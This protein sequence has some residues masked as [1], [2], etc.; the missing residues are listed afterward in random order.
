MPFWWIKNIFMMIPSRRPVLTRA[1]R[2]G[3]FLLAGAALSAAQQAPYAGSGDRISTIPDASQGNVEDSGKFVP[4]TTP[5]KI[6]KTPTAPQEWKDS[7]SRLIEKTGK[8]TFRIGIVECDREA[9][10]LTIPA[11]LNAREGLIEYALVTRQGKIH[12]SLLS[13]E[14][15]PLHVQ[16]A[17]LLLGMSPHPGKPQP[18]EVMIEVEWATNGPMRKL[19][20]EDL[21]ALVK[22]TPQNES[23]GTMTR[24]PWNFTGSQI[25]SQG[26]VAAREGSLIALIGDPAAVI[27][28][29]RPGRED[30]EL[31]VPNGAVLPGNGVPIAVRISL[32]NPLLPSTRIP[33]KP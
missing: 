21:V 11:R 22:D 17:A 13:T 32:E 1:L 2:S 28:N 14:A 23:G 5:E 12:E 18:C 26:F 16:M 29:P 27:V 20:L 19:P 24:G 30:D 6:S 31:H 10:T 9:R 3:I 25:D 4:A 33:A 15:E 7:A 8:H